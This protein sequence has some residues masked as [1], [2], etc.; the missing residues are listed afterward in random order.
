[1]NDSESGKPRGYAFV[2]YQHIR[3]MKSKSNCVLW[4]HAPSA[5]TC[6]SC[7][8]CS[9][10]C[11]CSFDFYYWISDSPIIGYSYQHLQLGS[12]THCPL[13]RSAAYKQADGR[14]IDSK[15]LIVDVERGRTVPNWRPRRLGGGLGS[16]RMGGDDLNQRH[17]GR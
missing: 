9:L 4:P 11:C 8:W 2:E 16:T 6:P 10:S 14:K 3:D 15:R 12:L 17:S 13:G 7:P 1:M 5:N